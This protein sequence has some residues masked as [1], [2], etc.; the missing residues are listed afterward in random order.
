MDVKLLWARV[1]SRHKY[2]LFRCILYIFI[3]FYVIKPFFEQKNIDSLT[4]LNTLL[5]TLS[6]LFIE[7]LYGLE[8]FNKFSISMRSIG[9]IVTL[10][11]M[12]LIVFIMTSGNE[13]NVSKEEVIESFTLFNLTFS[14][15]YLKLLVYLLPACAIF[16]LVFSVSKFEVVEAIEAEMADNILNKQKSKQPVKITEEDRIKNQ[17]RAMKSKYI[18]P[19]KEE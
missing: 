14:V 13:F 2:L 3:S 17:I 11:Y 16:D 9:I 19:E 10:F 7:Y 4:F 18:E 8:A 6:P 12:I 1:D 15:I 5:I